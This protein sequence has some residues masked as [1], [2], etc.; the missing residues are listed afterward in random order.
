[1]QFGELAALR[2]AEWP[3]WAAECGLPYFPSCS[4]GWDA[5]PRGAWHPSEPPD[6]FPWSPVVVDGSPAAFGA[7]VAAAEAFAATQ[8]A[9]HDGRPLEP[10]TFL[11]SWNEWT[12]GHAIEPAERAGDAWL[13]ALPP[14]A[15][16]RRA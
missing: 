15:R 10:A 1:M 7:H 4:P 8:C 6:R 11:A 14:R 16:L 5:T 2:E 3:R 12:E 9:T 13:A